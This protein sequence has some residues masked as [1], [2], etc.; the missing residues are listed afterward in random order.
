[1]VCFRYLEKLPDWKH[2]FHSF[3]LPLLSQVFCVIGSD[4]LEPISTYYDW[5][6]INRGNLK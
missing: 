4:Y 5:W 1:M 3:F 6:P 2:H